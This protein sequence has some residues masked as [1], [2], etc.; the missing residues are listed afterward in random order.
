[1]RT[2]TVVAVTAAI[3]VAT[4]VTGMTVRVARGGRGVILL[5]RAR[6]AECDD[7]SGCSVLSLREFHKYAAS[8]A[9]KAMRE[10]LRQQ[11]LENG[12]PEAE[13]PPLP[14]KAAI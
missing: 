9:D 3:L 5:T 6:A 4:V 11:Q 8:S 1:M 13:P 2:F 7:G 14:P 10:I 12:E